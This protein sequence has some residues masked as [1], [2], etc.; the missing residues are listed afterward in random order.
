MN[1]TNFTR[2]KKLKLARTP[3]PSLH[4]ANTTVKIRLAFIRAKLTNSI[5]V[6]CGLAV[7]S[8][9]YVKKCRSMQKLLYNT[10]II[11]VHFYNASWEVDRCRC[12][13]NQVF[14]IW[15]PTRSISR[16]RVF[17]VKS[18][19]VEYA[20]CLMGVIFFVTMELRESNLNNFNGTGMQMGWEQQSRR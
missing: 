8:K 7:A 15:T 5:N 13:V 1:S 4:N 12:T 19:R 9:I 11:F 10:L 20:R 14:A 16:R 3:P 6:E 18:F 2:T 17:V